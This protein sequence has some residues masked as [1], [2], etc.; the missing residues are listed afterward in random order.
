M[1][2]IRSGESFR[3]SR[4]PPLFTGNFVRLNSG[5]PKLLVVDDSHAHHVVVAWRD[6]DGLVHEQDFPRSSVHRIT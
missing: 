1:K 2:L 5:G 6:R 3:D 4:E